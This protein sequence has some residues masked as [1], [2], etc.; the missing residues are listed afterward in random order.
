MPLNSFCKIVSNTCI[1]NGVFRI[2]RH[3]N[4]ILFHGFLDCFVASLQARGA[5][6]QAKVRSVEIKVVPLSYGIRG[7]FI[8]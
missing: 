7:G 2:S 1:N 6:R 5:R 4:P 3:I 8:Y